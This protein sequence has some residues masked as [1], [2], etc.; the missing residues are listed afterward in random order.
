MR[1][2]EIKYTDDDDGGCPIFRLRY[3]ARDKEHAEMMFLSGEDAEGWRIL[4]IT[5]VKG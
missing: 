1:L 3:R 5:R 4:S 2:Y